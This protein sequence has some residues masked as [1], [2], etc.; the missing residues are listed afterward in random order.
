MLDK[1]IDGKADESILLKLE[2]TGDVIKKAS[3]CGLGK[4][5]PSPVISTMEK[6]REEYEAHVINGICETNNCKALATIEIDA[7]LCIGC[8]ICAK[9]CPVNAISGE[10]KQAHIIDSA[11]CTKCGI[12]VSVCKFNAIKGF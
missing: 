6:F 7:A 4:T 5:A 10:K 3:L 9:K 1:I 12:C 8:R 11:V 2:E